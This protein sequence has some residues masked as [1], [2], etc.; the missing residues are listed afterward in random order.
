ML[1]GWYGVGQALRACGDLALLREM[2]SAWPFF[3]ATVDNLEM[4]LSKSDMGIAALYATLVE[5]QTLGGCDLRAHP[6]HVAPDSGESARRHR[7]D[8]AAGEASGARG[9]DPPAAAIHRAAEPAAG[10]N[11]Q[12]HRAGENDPRVREGFSCPSMRS[13]PRCATA[14]EIAADR[15]CR[16]EPQ[17]A[18]PSRGACSWTRP[19]DGSWPARPRPNASPPRRD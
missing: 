11:A 8:A 13:R 2:S 5:D 9:F 12:R 6:R 4:V 15:Q 1:P 16:T 10:G 19:T 17:P 18:E 7:T 14:A 3:R